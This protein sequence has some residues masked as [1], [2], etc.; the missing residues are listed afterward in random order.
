MKVT[1]KTNKASLAILTTKY[2]VKKGQKFLKQ[3]LSS[4]SEREAKS[5]I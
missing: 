5:P 3:N 4:R 2:T 1:Y